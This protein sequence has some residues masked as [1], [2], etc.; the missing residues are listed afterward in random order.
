MSDTKYLMSFTTGGLFYRESIEVAQVYLDLQ[1]WAAVRDR[2]IDDNL[3]QT[4]TVNTAR[5]ICR[6]IC[7]RLKQ[8]TE[9]EMGILVDGSGQDQRYMLWV[10]VCRRYHFIRDFAVEVIREKYLRL[11]M[12][13]SYDDY[14]AFFNARAEW[15]DELERLAETTR[16]KLRRVLFKMLREADLL[17]KG[18]TI[19]PVM[20]TPRVT[21]IISRTARADLAVFPVSDTDLKEW[22]G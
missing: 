9:D 18:H 22:A 5:R 11:D 6:E 13:L 19:N 10:T 21:E 14:D 7:S 15:H 20:L 12:D 1:D 17:T 8:L 3:L 16:N 4:R 2:V